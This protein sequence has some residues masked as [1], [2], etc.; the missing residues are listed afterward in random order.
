MICQ[1]QRIAKDRRRL[2]EGN[3]VLPSIVRRFAWVPFKIHGAISP[4]ASD[5][6]RTFSALACST[7]ALRHTWRFLVGEIVIVKASEVIK[8][9]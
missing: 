6:S 7:S 4:V 3:S 9:P 5:R 1:C 2:V 8:V